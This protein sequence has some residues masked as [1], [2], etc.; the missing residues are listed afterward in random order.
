[1]NPTI[2]AAIISGLFAL[3]SSILTLTLKKYFDQRPINTIPAGRRQA[4]TGTWKGK[5]YQEKGPKGE[6]IEYPGELK[7]KAGRKIVSGEF[8]IESG[9]TSKE[10]KISFNAS[11]GFLYDNFLQLNY[12]SKDKSKIHFGTVILKLN[13]DATKLDGK[14]CGY[15]RITEDIISGIVKTEYRSK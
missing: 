10:D 11:G 13:A 8:N 14:F 6:P 2:V 15:G 12:F 4:I 1:M 3:V 5:I 7:L 9:L